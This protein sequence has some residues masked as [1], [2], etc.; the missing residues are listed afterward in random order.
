MVCVLTVG[1]QVELH[2]PGGGGDT[3]CLTGEIFVHHG[4]QGLVERRSGISRRQ[5]DGGRVDASVAVGAAF[6]NFSAASLLSV[7]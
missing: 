4:H 3:A 2:L 6:A 7:A 1:G 5:V